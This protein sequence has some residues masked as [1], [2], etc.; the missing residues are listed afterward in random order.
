MGDPLER[1]YRNGRR[2]LSLIN[3]VLDLAN[4]EAGRLHLLVEEALTAELVASLGPGEQR[5]GRRKRF[6]SLKPKFCPEHA[7][8]YRNR[9]QARCSK[10]SVFCCLTRSSLRIEGRVL[11]KVGPVNK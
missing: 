10:L 8:H 2:L 4:I 1:V 3:D 6:D 9:H 5:S 11:L 7:S